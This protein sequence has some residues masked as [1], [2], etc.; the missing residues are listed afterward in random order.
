MTDVDGSNGGSQT[1]L[2]NKRTY[3]LVNAVD[4]LLQQLSIPY[5]TSYDD[6]G[7]GDGEGGST[8]KSSSC[9]SG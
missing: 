2:V 1:Y 4:G 7:D 8:R 9:D 3:E 6:E 5:D